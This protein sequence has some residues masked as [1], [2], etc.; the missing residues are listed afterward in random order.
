MKKINQIKLVNLIKI[1]III[2]QME[3]QYRKGILKIMSHNIYLKN[4]CSMN[5][6]KGYW[7][8]IGSMEA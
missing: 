4:L 1:K 8:R 5:I 7:N 6:H 3:I 2:I